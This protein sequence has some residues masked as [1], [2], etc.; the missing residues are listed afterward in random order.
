MDLLHKLEKHPM[1]L[2]NQSSQV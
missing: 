2:K 1:R